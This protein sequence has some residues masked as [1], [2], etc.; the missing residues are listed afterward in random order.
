[1]RR[2]RELW[3]CSLVAAVVAVV[4]LPGAPALAAADGVD[5]TVRF[6]PDRI[7]VVEGF[8][9]GAWMLVQNKGTVAATGVTV[10]LDISAITAPSVDAV[11]PAVTPHCV[12]T[13]RIV[14]CALGSLEPGGGVQVYPLEYTAAPDS[15][16]I[17]ADIP[18]TA[19]SDA[20]DANPADNSLELPFAVTPPDPVPAMLVADVNTASRRVGPGQ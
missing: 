18:V 19:T 2:T 8:K 20:Q 7:R 17:T 11:V 15:A 12:L 10:K 9:S 5:L 14:S 16:P 4:A 13:V 1:M 6:D 3:V